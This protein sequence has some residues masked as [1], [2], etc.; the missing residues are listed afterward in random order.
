MGDYSVRPFVRL[1][2]SLSVYP[3]LLTQE[4]HPDSLDPV[5]A[6]VASLC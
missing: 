4:L 1:S 6:I 3:L 5:A 2:V